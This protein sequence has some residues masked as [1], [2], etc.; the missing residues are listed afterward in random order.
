MQKHLFRHVRAGALELSHRVVM[1]PMTRIRATE[2]S[3]E[4]TVLTVKYYSQR[5]SPGGLIISEATH[6]SPEATPVW[7]I[8]PTVRERGGHVPGIW[9]KGQVAA[10]RRV[11]DAVHSRGGKIVCQLLHTGRIAQP[12]IGEHPMVR[13]RGY[14]LPPVSSSAVGLSAS[15]EKGNNYNWDVDSAIPRALAA[16]ELSRVYGDYQHAATNAMAAGF[17]AVELHAAHGYLVDQFLADGVN[18]RTDDYGGSVANRCRFLFGAVDA[19]IGAVGSG[20]VGVRLSPTT[21]SDPHS[22]FAA[23]CTDA[24]EVYSAAVEGLNRFPG[25]A[26]LLLTEPR[27]GALSA[28]AAEDE[29]FTKPLCNARYRERFD[30]TLIGAG[31]FTPATAAQAVADGHYDLVAFGRWFASN[32]DL[33]QRLYDGTP[34][35]VYERDR[36]YGGGEEGYTDYPRSTQ[37]HDTTAAQG[38]HA[39]VRLMQQVDIGRGS[40]AN[41]K[42]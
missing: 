8:Y 5:A 40:L 4:P 36:F 3:L 31:G 18:Q 19:L 13:G 29:G 20:R 2:E 38:R 42:C 22:Y 15:K 17:D 39:P 12:G 30:G 11:T 41:T 28:A 10:W 14:P 21:P 27:V 37:L 34:L 32:P 33:P 35:N 25:L 6:I 16:S 23:T 1:A 26:Y 24:L 9:T 7:D